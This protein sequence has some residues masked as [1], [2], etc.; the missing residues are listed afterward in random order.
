MK[1]IGIHKKLMILTTL[2]GI[3]FLVASCGPTYVRTGYGYGRPYGYDYPRR[4][5][6]YAVPPPVVV[7]PRYCPP[8]RRGNGYAYGRRRWR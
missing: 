1:K 2:V 4:A 7:V 3:M 8:P 6:R 5:Y